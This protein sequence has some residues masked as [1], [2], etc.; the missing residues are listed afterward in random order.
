MI[1]FSSSE[2]LL[3]IHVD[4][5]REDHKFLITH[6]TFSEMI[7]IYSL[8]CYI[9]NEYLTLSL[10]EKK[11]EKWVKSE[12]SKTPHKIRDSLQGLFPFSREV[13]YVFN[14]NRNR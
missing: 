2:L 13:D 12:K 9:A 8:L 3:S 10:F 4:F 6:A 11:W 7:I 1:L 14:N 5:S